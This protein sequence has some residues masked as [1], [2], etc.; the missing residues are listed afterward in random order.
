M[1]TLTK[2]NND[3]DKRRQQRDNYDDYDKEEVGMTK[4]ILIVTIEGKQRETTKAT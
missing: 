4:E 3:T 1:I 2:A